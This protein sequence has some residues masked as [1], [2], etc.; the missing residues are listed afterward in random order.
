MTK[1][2]LCFLLCAVLVFSLT[3]CAGNSQNLSANVKYSTAHE[4]YNFLSEDTKSPEGYED[5]INS[6]TDF[7]IELFKSVYKDGKSSTVISPVSAILALSM[8]ANGAKDDTQ[9]EFSDTIFQGMNMDYVNKC[10]SYLLQRLQFFKNDNCK[11]NIA[12]SIWFSK[13]INVESSFLA[14]NKDFYEAGI[15]KADLQDEKTLSDI[16]NFVKDNTDGMIEKIIDEM[17]PDAQ[18]LL[19]NAIALED[20]WATEYEKECVSNSTFFGANGDTDAE[21]MYSK[22][23]Y[24]KGKDAQGF[25]KNY[26]NL[27]LKFVAILPN[28]DVNISDYI[29]KLSYEDFKNM[30]SSQSGISKCDAFLPKFNFDFDTNLKENLKS[31]GIEKAFSDSADFS[32]IT[33]DTKLFIN[34]VI[35]KAHIETDENGTKAA[36]ATAITMVDTTAALDEETPTVKLD[37][38]FVFALVDNESN[39]PVFIGCVTDI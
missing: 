35:H 34:S 14:K 36:A 29:D 37:R 31:L 33:T 27:P 28:E 18:M 19:L 38:P 4:K 2:V 15:F 24:I 10:S 13:D 9:K 23:T 30:L 3:A 11:L 17:N 21:F 22:E 5:Y 7:S 32:K 12:N 20:E 39:L 1:K 8:C 6:T 16:N 25:V 26:K